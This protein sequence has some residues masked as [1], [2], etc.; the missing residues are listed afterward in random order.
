MFFYLL[1]LAIFFLTGNYIITTLLSGI[2]ASAADFS[3]ISFGWKNYQK[4]RTVA[5]PRNTHLK[6]NFVLRIIRKIL[7]LLTVIALTFLQFK[8]AVELFLSYLLF[9]FVEISWEKK[10]KYQLTKKKIKE[11]Y[12]KYVNYLIDSISDGIDQIKN[13]VFPDFVISYFLDLFGGYHEVEKRKK[14]ILE[15]V[16]VPYYHKGINEQDMQKIRDYF[17]KRFDKLD[18]KT[19]LAQII[20]SYLYGVYTVYLILNNGGIKDLLGSTN[21]GWYDIVGLGIVTIF[22]YIN[23]VVR[24]KY[25]KASL[26]DKTHEVWFT[27]QL[28]IETERKKVL[29][30]WINLTI[31]L[32]LAILFTQ[33]LNYFS[34]QLIGFDIYLTIFTFLWLSLSVFLR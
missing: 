19:L 24:K 23:R 11:L 33:F 6:R 9:N 27:K 34:N 26:I 12:Y 10:W 2:L 28:N 21:L 25:G 15:D 30:D 18:F 29:N 32:V 16:K 20:S 14:Q 13:S 5:E 31:I 8:L 17:A 3:I 22:I 1:F 4:S 7:F